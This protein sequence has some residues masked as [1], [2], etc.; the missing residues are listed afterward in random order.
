MILNAF[1]IGGVFSAG[2]HKHE[3]RDQELLKGVEGDFNQ[4]NSK[5]STKLTSK[6]EILNKVLDEY[7]TEGLLFHSINAEWGNPASE[8]LTSLYTVQNKFSQT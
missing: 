7:N 8:V 1:C 3:L 4:D 2:W 6:S 5:R